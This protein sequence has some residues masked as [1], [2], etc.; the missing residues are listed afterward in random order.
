MKKFF[1]MIFVALIPVFA[2]AQTA[3]LKGSFEPLK[4]VTLLDADI[5]FDHGVYKFIPE[6]QFAA[7]YPDWEQIKKETTERFFR[8]LNQ[9]LKL[10]RKA[11]VMTNEQDFTIEVT[12]VNVDDR[13]NTISNV[14]VT[15]AEGKAVAQISNLYGRGG[16][17]GTFCNLMG[18]GLQSTGEKIG[19]MISYSILKKKY[20]DR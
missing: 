7:E 14:E 11:A 3:V 20:I 9:T 5:D 10:T 2:G 6:K 1:L 17:F 12:I 8:G 19:R 16:R 15:D 18:D 4:D 13:G